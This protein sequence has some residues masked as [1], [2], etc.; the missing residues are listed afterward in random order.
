MR[1][2]SQKAH[3]KETEQKEGYTKPSPKYVQ[4]RYSTNYFL[5]EELNHLKFNTARGAMELYPTV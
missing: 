4:I 5:E 1:G 3:H 2:V